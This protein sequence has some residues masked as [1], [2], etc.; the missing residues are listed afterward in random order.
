[1]F[2]HMDLGFP[3]VTRP[4]HPRAPRSGCSNGLP[5]DRARLTDVFGGQTRTIFPHR[6][7]DTRG[8]ARSPSECTS[9]SGAETRCYTRPQTGTSPLTGMTPNVP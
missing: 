8:A 5:K 1:M 3:A 9:S 7:V 6:N 4:A 2:P